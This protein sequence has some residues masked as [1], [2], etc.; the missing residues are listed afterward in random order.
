MITE[1]LAST[2]ATPILLDNASVGNA[3]KRTV[4]VSSGPKAMPAVGY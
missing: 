4:K 2:K 3:G 1:A